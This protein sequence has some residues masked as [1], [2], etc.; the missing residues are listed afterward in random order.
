VAFTQPA[1]D[2]GSTITSYT[3]T[4]SPG[5]ITGTLS[6]SGSGTITVTGLSAGTSYTFTVT[7]TNSV[8]TSSASSASNSITTYAVPGAPTIGTAT[9]TSTTT[10]T[11]AFT[12]PASDGGSTIT[13]Y[14]ATSSPGSITGTLSQAGSGTITVSGLSESTSY[15]FTV[16]A[17]N[18]V[19][20]GS[21]SSASNSI[22]TPSS[23]TYLAADLYNSAGSNADSLW[24]IT[25]D[26]TGNI[27][28]SG[29][30]KYSG[31]TVDYYVSKLTGAGAITWQRALNGGGEYDY[32]YAIC[33]DSSG[34]VYSCGYTNS[35]TYAMLV[36]K[37]NSSGTIQWQR[38]CG[39]GNVFFEGRGIALDSSGNVFVVAGGEAGSFP[40]N[41]YGIIMKLNG[42]TGAKL[43]QRYFRVGAEI[44]GPRVYLRGVSIDSSDNVFVAGYYLDSGF[45]ASVLIAKYNNAL[46]TQAWNINI[47]A[48]NGWS[49]GL[50]SSGNL[51][52]SGGASG[53]MYTIKVNTSGAIQ[54][55]KSL[56]Y[57]AATLGTFAVAVHP[58]SG[59]VYGVGNTNATNGVIVF[60][61]NSS[62]TLQWGRRLLRTG[63][64]NG[65]SVY[66]ISVNATGTAIFLA[67]LYDAA[68]T[69][70]GPQNSSIWVFPSDGSK[71]GTYTVNGRGITWSA[72][73]LTESTPT[74]TARTNTFKDP[75]G[76]LLS[77]TLSLTDSAG[78][79]TA[80]VTVIT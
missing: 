1:F 60:K 40:S 52:Y 29:R 33:V 65:P 69:S 36:T 34:N 27:Y 47:A 18:S 10:A 78:A 53:N 76:K 64:G 44:N 23:V 4:S 45:N 7:A 21:A 51:Y 32:S 49:S 55:Q 37:Y 8:G 43:A 24:A 35:N 26:S 20:T 30:Q 73:T 75:G 72:I 39:E 31:V 62:G 22:T 16:T 79:L 59:D 71:T 77:N 54:W 61:L 13:S 67:G 6:Q 42:S 70:G 19:G 9:A 38:G 41:N 3:A 56:T 48:A 25:S 74:L 11:V 5:S 28:V 63:D 17:T 12:A 68:A 15:T 2:G 14:T 66:G 50:D 58:S 57:S 46:T 80:A